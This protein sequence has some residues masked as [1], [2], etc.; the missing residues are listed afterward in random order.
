MS[1]KIVV[2]RAQAAAPER[3]FGCSCKSFLAVCSFCV[4]DLF[5]VSV[6]NLSQKEKTLQLNSDYFFYHTVR[7]F[8]LLVL[9]KK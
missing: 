2:E 7:F 1:D 9:T 6:D 8:L 5:H 3:V 4:T